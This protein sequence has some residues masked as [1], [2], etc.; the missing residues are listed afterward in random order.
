[1]A[2]SRLSA[3]LMLVLLLVLL[4]VLVFSRVRLENRCLD[5]VPEFLSEGVGH[6]AELAVGAPPAG[7]GD[8]Q[9]FISLDHPEI[10]NDEGAVKGDGGQR[11]HPSGHVHCANLHVRDYQLVA[12]LQR[13]YAGM[14]GLPIPR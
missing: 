2:I 10:V 11:F 7:H 14:C 5:R 4:L 12:T 3:L 8:E 13:E 9:P 6:V 1:M